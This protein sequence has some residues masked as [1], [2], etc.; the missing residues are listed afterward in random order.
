[1]FKNSNNDNNIETGHMCSGRA[2]KEVHLV[3]LFKKNYGDAV[4]TVEKR[5]T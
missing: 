4:S 3:N 1:M 2:F 5:Q